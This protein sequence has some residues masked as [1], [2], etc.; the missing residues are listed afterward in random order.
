MYVSS[1]LGLLNLRECLLPD[2]DNLPRAVNI[3]PVQPGHDPNMME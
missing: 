2:A 1:T 3:S